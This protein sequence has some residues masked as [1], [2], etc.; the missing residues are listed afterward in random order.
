M[1]QMV[2]QGLALGFGLGRADAIGQDDVAQVRRGAFGRGKRQDVGRP[3]PVA[4]PGVQIAHGG[5]VGQQDDDIAFDRAQGRAG[6]A[7]DHGFY[8]RQGE[9][10][11]VRLDLD[12]DHAGSSRSGAGRPFAASA[13]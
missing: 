12:L 13:S 8:V 6:C 10:P 7:F 2:D 4:E 3:V 5:V 11:V 9:G 1:A